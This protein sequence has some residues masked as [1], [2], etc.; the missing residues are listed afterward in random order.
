[1]LLKITKQESEILSRISSINQPNLKCNLNPKNSCSR[2]FIIIYQCWRTSTISIQKR[3]FIHCKVS[4]STIIMNCIFRRML[5]NW[6][7]SISNKS[8]F[9]FIDNFIVRNDPCIEIRTS[10]ME[11]DINWEDAERG[12]CTSKRLNSSNHLRKSNF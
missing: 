8:V 12:Y 5:R 11:N 10:L 2:T 1:M 4:W 7:T 6:W 9:F 3:C